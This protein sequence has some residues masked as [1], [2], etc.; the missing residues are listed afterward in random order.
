MSTRHDGRSPA[1]PRPVEIQ[2][3]FAR[4]SDGS[5]LY[6]CG[7]TTLLVTANLVEGVPPWLEGRGV[8]WLTAEYMMLPGST[9]PRKPRKADGRSTE[10]QRLIGR[11]LRAA[12]DTKALGPRTLSVDAEVIDADGGTRTAAITGAFVAVADALRTKL[13]PEAA[14]EASAGQRRGD[15]RRGRRRRRAARPRLRRGRRGRG[16]P[17]RRPARRRRARRGPG[18]RRGGHLQ[19]IAARRAARP[20]RAAGST[21]LTARQRRGPRRRLA[22]SDRSAESEAAAS[23]RPPAAAPRRR[24]RA[25]HVRHPDPTAAAIETTVDARS[26]LRRSAAVADGSRTDGNP[27]KDGGIAHE[28]GLPHEHLS[29]ALALVAAAAG[30]ATAQVPNG[31]PSR[32]AP[33]P[34]PN[35]APP[36]PQVNAGADPAAGQ[37]Y[38]ERR[39]AAGAGRRG[40]GGAERPAAD[41]A[42]RALPAD[43]RDRPVH[44]RWPT[45]SAA[46][47]RS[48]RRTPWRSSCGASTGCRPTSTS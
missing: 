21:A 14:T 28:I 7:G 6:R 47:T 22:D 16:R 32:P 45:S 11:S 25:P 27:S 48:R 31:L 40:R 35:P 13:G 34:A 30:V 33:A 18:D 41:R 12:V 2:R 38:R 24:P 5:V 8:G 39:R 4:R 20:G 1:D 3:G 29:M 36:P 37:V 26:A 42:A 10:I 17:E 44:G 43:Q 46:T 23:G 15:Q 19:P 9:T